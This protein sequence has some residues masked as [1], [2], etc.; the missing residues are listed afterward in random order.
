[1][2]YVLLAIL[3]VVSGFIAYWG[4][5]LGRRMGKRRLTLFGLRPRYTAI[6]VTTITGMIIAAFTLGAMIA[7]NQHFRTLIVEGKKLISERALL[8]KQNAELRANIGDLKRQRRDLRTRVHEAMAGAEKAEKAQAVAESSVRKLEAEVRL[9]STQLG[10]VK[11]QYRTASG[12][13]E[14]KRRELRSADSQLQKAARLL[15]TTTQKL[16]EGQVVIE[17]Y[18]NKPIIGRF[19]EEI[20]RSVIHPSPSA[21]RDVLALLNKASDV[22]LTRGGVRGSNGRA[23]RIVTVRFFSESTAGKP[24][25]R[26]LK[27][28][29]RIQEIVREISESQGDVVAVV[30]VYA[31]SVKGQQ[32]LVDVFPY[33]NKIGFRKGEEITSAVVD[34]SQ[35]SGDVFISVMQLLRVNVREAV[36]AAHVIPIFDPEETGGVGTISG[37]EQWDE[38]IDLVNRIKAEN[39]PVTVRVT[40]NED[41]YSAGITL[42]SLRFAVAKPAASASGRVLR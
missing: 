30:R 21:T 34:G 24:Q 32:T 26:I 13:L 6:V 42:S 20:A 4:D 39:K 19:G 12:Q 17:D 2:S 1:M 8:T 29:Q 5:L 25:S 31:N 28:G 41:I 18:F 40:A 33:N 9:R 38:L 11:R 3:V 22:M 16:I 7:T 27:E 10:E 23:V 35:S 36:T 14:T 15:G 37:P